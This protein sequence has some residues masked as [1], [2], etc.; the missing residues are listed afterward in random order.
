M[1]TANDTASHLRSNSM[2]NDPV[3]LATP[4][5]ASWQQQLRDAVRDV[6]ELAALLE[7]PRDAIAAD[8]AARDF[9]LLVPRAY[10]ARMKKGDPRDPLLLQVLPTAL[11][12]VE[13]PG[14]THDPLS[15]SE[16]AEAGLVRKY[17]DRSLLITTG[18]CP[19]HCRYCFRRSFPYADQLAA[20]NDFADALERLG[21][22]GTKEAILSGGDPLSLGNARLASLLER[23]AALP[24]LRRVR[25][26][27]RFPI[28]LPDRIDRGLVALLERARVDVVI[29]LHTNHPREIDEDVAGALRALRG[30]GVTLLNQ[31]VLLR[32]IND[33]AD[34][35]AELSE[36][37][38]ECRTL[39]YYLHLLDPVAGAAH[40]DVGGP[41]AEA[42][43]RELLA[44][45]PGY[46]VPRL[47]REIPGQA[48]KTPIRLGL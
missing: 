3:R 40:F 1:A 11:E 28:V 45:L 25:V 24:A 9:P 10:I 29:V 36:R 2:T 44:R 41:R 7:L 27:T 12:A 16:F 15:E 6:A 32:G 20:R 46:L 43:Y 14:F 8:A 33:D 19:V 17:R 34:T 31:S 22:D 4:A 35:L 13:V 30:A 26:H 23:L 18:A 37:L 38:F 48:S 47:V 39:P 42:I 21:R 5:R